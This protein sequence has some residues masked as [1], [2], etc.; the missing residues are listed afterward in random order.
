MVVTALG[1][2]AYIKMWASSM[3][4]VSYSFVEYETEADL[5]QAQSRI[6]GQE[7]HGSIVSAQAA[8]C[9]HLCMSLEL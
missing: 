3:L 7:F 4:T 9:H 5:N 6:D 1:M 2:D 8:V